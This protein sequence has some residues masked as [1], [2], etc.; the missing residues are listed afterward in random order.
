MSRDYLTWLMSSFPE[1]R[2]LDS[3]VMSR[4]REVVQLDSYATTLPKSELE[5]LDRWDDSLDLAWSLVLDVWKVFCDELMAVEHIGFDCDISKALAARD[6]KAEDAVKVMSMCRALDATPAAAPFQKLKNIANVVPGA[7][8]MMA[9]GPECPVCSMRDI[10][11]AARSM[12]Y[13]AVSPQLGREMALFREQ[14]IHP[15]YTGPTADSHHGAKYGSAMSFDVAAFSAVKRMEVFLALL[16]VEE[17]KLKLKG[18]N[19]QT[20][21]ALGAAVAMLPANVCDSKRAVT[22]ALVSKKLT[23]EAAF[24]WLTGSLSISVVTKVHSSILQNS[25]VTSF[26]RASAERIILGMPAQSM[27]GLTEL[28]ILVGALMALFESEMMRDS[29]ARRLC[30]I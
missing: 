7:K 21:L 26:A 4:V 13:E 25:I 1:T 12:V 10:T 28:E 29:R 8:K 30:G 17:D 16:K 6:K 3:A 5:R 15:L 19:V 23:R 9:M 24:A 2:A 18:M 14:M 27:F 22:F 20:G 11:E